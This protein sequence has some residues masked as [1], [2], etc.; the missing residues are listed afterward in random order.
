LYPGQNDGDQD[1]ERLEID[2]P[3]KERHGVTCS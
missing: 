2:E 3:G 1:H